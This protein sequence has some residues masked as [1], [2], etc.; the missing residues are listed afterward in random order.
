MLDTAVRVSEALTL[1]REK[2]DSCVMTVWG[3]GAKE[4]TVPF[5]I[6]MRKHLGKWVQGNTH[7]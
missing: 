4:R 7:A 5:S 1:K 6:E 3:K 2:L